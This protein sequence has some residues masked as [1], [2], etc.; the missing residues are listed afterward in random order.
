MDVFAWNYED[1]SEFDLKIAQHHLNIRHGTKPRMQ[2]P[3]KAEVK[4][5]KPC[6]FIREEQHPDWL[7]NVVPVM[8]KNE[9]VR[10]HIDFRNLN[11][12]WLK[13]FPLSIRGFRRMFFMGGFYW[14]NQIKLCL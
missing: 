6:G 9:K 10:V 14:Y 5:L 8:K 1:M 12:T 3:I 4:K 13:D 2:D 11:D 7:A